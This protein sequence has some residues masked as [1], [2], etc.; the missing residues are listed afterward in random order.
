ML[1]IALDPIANK[2]QSS[3]LVRCGR[4]WFRRVFHVQSGS[5][6]KYC[7]ENSISRSYISL[8]FEMR[9]CILI[10]LERRREIP[11]RR[12]EERS[13]VQF[14]PIFGR[15]RHVSIYVSRHPIRG[16]KYGIS[17][18]NEEVRSDNVNRSLISRIRQTR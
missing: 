6:V 12:Q 13:V 1:L 14:Q 5:N 17:K 8:R 2:L 16:R 11:R 4:N 15:F 18:Q 7:C 9:R 3:V 10:N